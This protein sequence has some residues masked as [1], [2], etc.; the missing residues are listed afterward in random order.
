M[1]RSLIARVERLEKKKAHQKASKQRQDRLDQEFAERLKD[2]SQR[3]LSP[4]DRAVA[5]AFAAWMTAR[6]EDLSLADEDEMRVMLSFY[7]LSPVQL[8]IFWVPAKQE[9]REWFATTF[10][11]QQLSEERLRIFE[12]EIRNLVGR[13]Y[14]E[15]ATANLGAVERQTYFFDPDD[16]SLCHFPRD[17]PLGREER[18]FRV[19]T[20][21]LFRSPQGDL[22]ERARI[23]TKNYALP[24]DE[25]LISRW[26]I[27]WQP[28][29]TPL[30][31]PLA[32]SPIEDLRTF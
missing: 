13:M 28:G 4:E 17:L 15:V 10:P 5:I 31:G 32:T 23:F 12:P 27:L 26:M 7:N 14:E 19:F 8:R 16:F 22:F 18:N 2:H 11:E 29:D 20:L 9:F 6:F 1:K 21:K 24:K 3:D 25:E 30:T